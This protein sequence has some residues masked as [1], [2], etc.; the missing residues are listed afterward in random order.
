MERGKAVKIWKAKYYW[1]L[2]TNFS[3]PGQY[4]ADT[5]QNMFFFQWAQTFTNSA[6]TLVYSVG[7]PNTNLVSRSYLVKML[8]RLLRWLVRKLQNRAN[9]ICER[10]LKI[11][12]ALLLPVTYLLKLMEC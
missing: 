2:L 5:N 3:F 8:A 7:Q 6:S 1:L 11:W 10:F 12:M 9:V 4:K